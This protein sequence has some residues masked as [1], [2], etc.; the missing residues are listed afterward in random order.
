MSP[1]FWK[2]PGLARA[3][4]VLMCVCVGS[5]WSGSVLAFDLSSLDVFGLFGTKEDAPQPT[6]T[7]L[8]YAVEFDVAGEDKNLV[9]V[10]KDASD[11]YKLRQDPPPGGEPLARRVEADLPRL[12]DAL[13]AAGRYNARLDVTVAGAP[14]AIGGT[15]IAAASRAAEAYRGRAAVPI[16]IAAVPGPLFKLRDIRT[17]DARTGAAFSPEAL[18]QRVVALAP[19]DPARAA[20]LRAAQARMI[21]EFRSQ[22]RPLAKAVSLSPVVNHAAETMDVAF[23]LDPGPVA[24]IG[25]IS[26]TGTKAVDPAVVRSFIYLEPGDP[27]SPKALSDTRKS[28][29]KIEA[30]GS[31]RIREAE[32]L[33]AGGALPVFVEVTERAPR[34]VG[35]SARYSTLD[36]PA[37]RAYFAHR[38]LFGGAERLR[39]EADVFL[40]PRI[41]GTK[42]KRIEDLEVSDIGARFSASF[43]KPALG[44]T[45]N[46][47][48]L[49]GVVARER[50][51]TNKIGGYTSRSA[52]ATAAI[53]HRFSDTFSVQAGIEAERG[54]SSDVLGKV[55]YTLVGTPVSVQ[56]DSTDNLLDPTRGF[57]ATATVTPY[58]SFLGSTV[59][60][61]QT[62]ATASTY[63][64]FDE[65]ARTVI[66]GRVGFGSDAGA[67][68]GEI[69][70]NR[71]FY[72]GGG[73]SVRGFSFR[74]L[75][76][77]GPLNQITGGRSLLEGSLEARIKVTD[78]IGVVPFVD[79]GNAFLSSIP[80]FS[81]ERLRMSAG[82]GLRYYTGIGPIRLDVAVPVD[83]K[84]GES[85]YGIYVSIGQAF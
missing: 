23:V 22:S 55:D 57:R 33:D 20:D 18:P 46:D 5:A 14:L 30:L 16:R 82:L 24:P 58:P 41:N 10:L 77:R 63:Y 69:P 47:L 85:A 53:R 36:G 50:Y 59:A 51:G 84:R 60:F 27:Y 26:V 31:V 52:T 6:P 76:P 35:F 21:D 29:A 72:A 75:G 61:T 66:A 12:I 62:R 25:D 73:G 65:S 48:L 38:N 42:I 74:S 83:R 64:A 70:S 43:L 54:Q 81:K 78:T 39:L 45:R 13:W 28:V 19:G 34:L 17:V 9:Q 7:S 37:L 11:T 71:R 67:E 1:V 32:A 4:L 40:A 3:V 8:P 68:L 49:D 15:G 79:V 2:R 56:Y 44:G 80:D